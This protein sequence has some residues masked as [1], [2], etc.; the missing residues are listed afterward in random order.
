ME[1]DEKEFEEIERSF[2]LDIDPDSI[3]AD[4]GEQSG[5]FVRRKSVEDSSGCKSEGIGNNSTGDGMGMDSS[6][7]VECPPFLLNVS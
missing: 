5:G 7:L 2:S 4:L 6:L 1:T 3:L